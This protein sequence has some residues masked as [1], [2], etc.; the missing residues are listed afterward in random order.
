MSPDFYTILSICLYIFSHLIYF[1][2]IWC[3]YIDIVLLFI[4][5]ICCTK[6]WSPLTYYSVPSPWVLG[7]GGGSVGGVCGKSHTQL[8]TYSPIRINVLGRSWLA[9]P[10]GHII[11]LY[12]MVCSRVPK[13]D[14]L[15]CADSNICYQYKHLSYNSLFLL[16]QEQ[17]P[18]GLWLPSSEL[19]TF[20]G[21]AGTAGTWHHAVVLVQFIQGT[22]V[23]HCVITW[24]LFHTKVNKPELVKVLT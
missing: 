5:Y 7:G 22:V 12:I 21:V 3:A 11:Y 20:W 17:R 14:C 15:A 13:Q 18:Y 23:P 24:C 2:V 10:K 9:A 19:Q 4:H 8:C 1:L 6:V 16:E